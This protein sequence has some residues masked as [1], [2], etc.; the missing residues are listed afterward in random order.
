MRC[1]GEEVSAYCYFSTVLKLAGVGGV[2]GVRIGICEVN[3]TKQ[4]NKTRVF[5]AKILAG[6][7]RKKFG[8]L[9]FIIPSIENIFLI[10][11]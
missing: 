5:L 7:L 11:C 1:R 3:K 4:I 10:D 8:K 6:N 2:G 9:F